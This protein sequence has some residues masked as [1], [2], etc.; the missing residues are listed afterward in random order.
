[1]NIIYPREGFKIYIPVNESGEKGKCILK[2]THK[3][4]SAILYWQLD[5]QFVGT[6]QKFHQISVLPDVGKHTLSITDS[7]GETTQVKFEVIGK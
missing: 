6:T 2:A 5:E 1:M 3:N 7:E 4:S